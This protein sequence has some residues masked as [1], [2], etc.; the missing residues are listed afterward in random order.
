[1][2]VERVEMALWHYTCDHG[3]EGIGAVGVV[4][5]TMQPILGVSLAWFTD[6]AAPDR[7]ALGLTSTVIACDRT[8][9]RYRVLDPARCEPWWQWC[10]R[11][12]VPRSRRE[13][14]EAAPGAAPAH[15]WVSEAALAVEATP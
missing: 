9:N 3:R 10:R 5:P 14:L 7:A 8:R 6:M 1:M 13:L 2:S 15:W 4:R 12:T 11:M